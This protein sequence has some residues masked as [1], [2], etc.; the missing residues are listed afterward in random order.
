MFH[1]EANFFKKIN[2]LGIRDLQRGTALATLVLI[3]P[4]FCLFF[5]ARGPKMSPAHDLDHINPPVKLANDLCRFLCVCVH[6]HRW[7]DKQ[8]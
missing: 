3:C 8:G 6:T 7:T 2:K 4:L 1:V 5:G